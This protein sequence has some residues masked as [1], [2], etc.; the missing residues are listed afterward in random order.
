MTTDASNATT[1]SCHQPVPRRSKLP[2]CKNLQSIERYTFIADPQQVKP[3]STMPAM[4][5]SLSPA[6]RAATAK[7]ITHYLNSLSQ[8][9]IKPLAP[10]TAAAITH[11]V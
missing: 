5:T 4:M 7:A 6:E 1:P 3:G 10:D 11:S 9:T 8:R 2:I